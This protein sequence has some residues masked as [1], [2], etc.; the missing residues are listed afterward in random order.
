MQK[1]QQLFNSSLNQSYLQNTIQKQF[2]KWHK[3]IKLNLLKLTKRFNHHHM[4]RRLDFI[5]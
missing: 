1:K 3:N 4:N 5:K 2:I